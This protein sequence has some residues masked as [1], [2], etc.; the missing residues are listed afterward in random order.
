LDTSRV[1]TGQLVAGVSGVGLFLFLFL[2]WYGALG[3]TRSA[4]ETF[5]VLDV[6]L[7]AIGLFAAA[8][9]VI[10]MMGGGDVPVASGRATLLA[11]IV[12]LIL[13]FFFAI[14]LT[15]GEFGSLSFKVGG[16]L[17]VLASV[18]IAAGGFMTQQPAPV[19]RARP[20]PPPP[21][22]PTPPPA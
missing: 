20:A 8:L 2:D 4:W 5:S 7:A 18:G 21:G 1:S 16:Y 3:Q 22:E 6:A 15:H 17:S 10:P 19:S 14:E 11:G 13:T 12:A 9:A